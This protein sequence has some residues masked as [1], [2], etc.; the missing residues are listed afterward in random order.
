MP[1]ASP[2]LIIGWGPKRGR[3]GVANAE[4]CVPVAKPRW[5]VRHW[6]APDRITTPSS[7]ENLHGHDP[8]SEQVNIDGLAITG[9]E[10]TEESDII[11]D[12]FIF[13]SDT[14]DPFSEITSSF[15]SYTKP[16]KGD[17]M[18]RFNDSESPIH[19]VNGNT[20]FGEESRVGSNQEEQLEIRSQEEVNF[21]ERVNREEE[22]REMFQEHF[23]NA[24]NENIAE[25]DNINQRTRKRH[26]SCPLLLTGDV[27]M[28]DQTCVAE[29]FKQSPPLPVQSMVLMLLL[30]RRQKLQD[31][32]PEINTARRNLSTARMSTANQRPAPCAPRHHRELRKLKFLFPHHYK[33]PLFIYKNNLN[34]FLFP[35]AISL[36]QLNGLSPAHDFQ[37]PE[38]SNIKDLE[39]TSFQNMQRNMYPSNNFQYIANRNERSNKTS[40][41]AA[42]DL[43]LKN[44]KSISIT[45]SSYLLDG[46]NATQSNK[47]SQMHESSHTNLKDSEVNDEIYMASELTQGKK[48]PIRYEQ[49]QTYSSHIDGRNKISLV[50]KEELEMSNPTQTVHMANS[51][52]SP[53]INMSGRLSNESHRSSYQPSCRSSSFSHTH[54]DRIRCLMTTSK[55]EKVGNL[56]QTHNTTSLN[57]NLASNAKWDQE[58]EKNNIVR[59]DTTTINKKVESTDCQTLSTVKPEPTIGLKQSSVIK[60]SP[61]K[62]ASEK[63][64][65]QSPITS[66]SMLQPNLVATHSPLSPLGNAEI[67]QDR[68]PIS[69]MYKSSKRKCE[70]VERMET[71]YLPRVSKKTKNSLHSWF[72]RVIISFILCLM[73]MTTSCAQQKDSE[74]ENKSSKLKE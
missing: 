43:S 30:H 72:S 36:P 34:P 3:L 46:Y 22:N 71:T 2:P 18:L 69:S 49:L 25:R 32:L 57:S 14:V 37:V 8:N 13:S 60:N 61:A 26:V 51:A 6:S 9:R 7:T 23:S 66:N 33:N 21:D 53:C 12:R 63:I 5:R 54:Y 67:V 73:A 17:S 4:M 24:Q 35:K 59:I 52:S 58:Y 44:Q 41:S 62:D 39:H 28:K 45:S 11:C 1:L 47:I 29:S 40:L 68:K 19:T 16:C 55:S 64:I 15:N 10:A 50:T 65:I 74:N 20:R 38:S 48:P 70:T 42:N 31:I 27:S 56:Q